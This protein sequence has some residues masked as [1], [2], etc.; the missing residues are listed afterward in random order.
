MG[1]QNEFEYSEQQGI[2]FKLIKTCDWPNRKRFYKNF[3][4]TV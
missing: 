1:E 2:F 4:E 3:E